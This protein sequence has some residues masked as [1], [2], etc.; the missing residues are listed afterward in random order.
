[1]VIGED[2]VVADEAADVVGREDGRG[3]QADLLHR[4]FET[5]GLHVVSD[6]ER[7][8]DDQKCPG[9]EI[10][11]QAGPGG[12]DRHAHAG[13]QCGE[14]SGLDTEVA[15]DRDHQHDVQRDV[16]DVADVALQRRVDFLARETGSDQA[17]RE[18]DQIAADDPCHD[19]A[20]NLESECRHRRACHLTHVLPIHVRLLFAYDL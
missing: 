14:R 13:D 9:R 7:P 17:Q 20:E 19:C 5:A 2:L 15:E 3:E 11:Q 18:M 8:Q 16:D 12:A 1:M 4:A 6:F 10:R